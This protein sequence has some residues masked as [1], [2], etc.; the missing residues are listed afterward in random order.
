METDKKIAAAI[1]A[2]TMYLDAEQQALAAQAAAAAGETGPEKVSP[3]A[4]NVW[5]VSGRQALMQ[6]G[7]LMQM[8]SFHG[9][10]RM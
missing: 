7:N 2:V 4:L 3:R 9:G 10:R 6:M 1:A 5:G 8:K